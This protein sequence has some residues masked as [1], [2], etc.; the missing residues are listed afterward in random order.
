MA[1]QAVL[2]GLKRSQLNGVCAGTLPKT[3]Y[4]LDRKKKLQ[5]SFNLL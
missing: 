5:K 2:I 1:L 3:L 4:T